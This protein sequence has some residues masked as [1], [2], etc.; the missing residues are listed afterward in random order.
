MRNLQGIF[1]RIFRAIPPL[2]PP[3]EMWIWVPVRICV[4]FTERGRLVRPPTFIDGVM[5]SL[6]SP[7]YQSSVSFAAL[8]TRVSTFRIA[9]LPPFKSKSCLSESSCLASVRGRASRFRQTCPRK[10]SGCS[11]QRL[12]GPTGDTNGASG[13]SRD[14][15]GRRSRE[16]SGRSQSL[17][18]R[19][20]RGS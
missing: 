16:K 19:R 7:R 15:L 1:P 3:L 17:R 10:N 4:R 5:S 14:S 18:G 8:R 13:A 9:P 12:C 11:S 2:H 20:G 6:S